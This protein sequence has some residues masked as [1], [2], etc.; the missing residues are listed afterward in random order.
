MNTSYPVLTKIGIIFLDIIVT[1]VSLV[2]AIYLRSFLGFSEPIY[3]QYYLN[4]LLV[5]IIIWRGLSEYQDAYAGRAY[6]SI[7]YL[8]TF[9]SIKKEIT[10]IFRTVLL[11]CLLV[12]L[13]SGIISY[14]IIWEH[15]KSL[16]VLFGA[17]NL[18]L[19]FLEKVIIFHYF[20]YIGK[21]PK[22]TKKVLILGTGDVAKQYISSIAGSGFNIIGII[23]KKKSE[24]GKVL[25][26]YK[27][28]GG[29]AN[30]T[31]ILH[32]TYID[33]L[34]VA[35][36]AKYLGDIEEVI[37]TCDKEGVPVRI[38]SPF[39]KNLISKSRAEIVNGMPNITFSPVERND[40]EMA[41]KR[42]ID[43]VV[44]FICI[45]VLMP[46]FIVIAIL[47]RLDSPGPVLYKWKILGLNKRPLTSYKLRTMV[48]NAEV[49]KKDLIEMNEMKGAAFKMTDDPRVTRIGKWLR[50]YSLDE[51]PQLFS[52]LIGDL[53]LVG[54]RPPL[55]TEVEKYEGWHRRKLSVKPGI[56]CLWQIS[57][58]NE[59][60]DFDEWMQLDLQYIDEW[61]LWLD[62]KIFF[63]TIPAVLS[64]SGR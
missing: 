49:L 46:I 58:R 19:L 61:S 6:K 53:S 16:I 32:S 1:I 21:R 51:L 31:N 57:G 18:T 30:L 63:K 11:G 41:M 15:P 45:V 42:L 34:I 50:K 20:E 3:W 23:G 24:K 39:F 7:R 36:P 37:N 12:Y 10:I 60:S 28:V 64:G 5:I 59:I 47:V 52:V 27:V 43:I 56:T 26:G 48:H 17:I 40:L 25:Y 44:S 22:N 13:V 35:L 55:Q 14:F 33:E 9:H 2:L 8:G 29:A 62:I 54:P 4:L 38:V